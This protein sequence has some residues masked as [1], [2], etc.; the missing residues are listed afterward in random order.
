VNR[1]HGLCQHCNHERIHG[2]GSV[3]KKQQEQSVKLRSTSKTPIKGKSGKQ[4]EVDAELHRIYEEMSKGDMVCSGCGST[5]HLSHSHIIR[6][7]WSTAFITVPENITYHC[8]VRL[9]GSKGCHDRH[10]DV[11]WMHTLLDYEKNMEYIKSVAPELYWKIFYKQ[12][13]L[14]LR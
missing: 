14:G 3:Q 2:E 5:K 10:E 7:S 9:D 1:K 13:E 4:K 11:E 6:R 8:L 12:K